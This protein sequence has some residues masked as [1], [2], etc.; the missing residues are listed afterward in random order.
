MDKDNTKQEKK[1]YGKFEIH[2]GEFVPITEEELKNMDFEEYPEYE[3]D[4]DEE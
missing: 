4:T 1:K 2:K 3:E